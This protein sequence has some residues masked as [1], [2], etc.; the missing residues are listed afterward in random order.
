MLDLRQV[1]P[2]WN[3]PAATGRE[4]QGEVL[5]CRRGEADLAAG[6]RERPPNEGAVIPLSDE[7]GDKTSKNE[8]AENRS[9]FL[10]PGPL[11][12][13]RQMCSPPPAPPSSSAGSQAAQVPALA[14]GGQRWRLAQLC[15]IPKP[16]LPVARPGPKHGKVL[17]NGH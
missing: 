3:D 14:A 17:V 4:D 6:Q 1:G 8:K 10:A 16:S 7:Q 2:G 15:P 12:P 11:G 13:S 9:S 5:G